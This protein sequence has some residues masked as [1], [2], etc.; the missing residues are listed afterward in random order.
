MGGSDSGELFTDIPGA[1]GPPLSLRYRVIVTVHSYLRHVTK[2]ICSTKETDVYTLFIIFNI[3]KA[4]VAQC[5]KSHPCDL[6]D[7]EQRCHSG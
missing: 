4:Q 1:S 2:H 7:V 3:V 6:N 5:V